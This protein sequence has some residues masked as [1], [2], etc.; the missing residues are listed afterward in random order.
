[1]LTRHMNPTESGDFGDFCKPPGPSHCPGFPYH[2]GG[3]HVGP[4]EVGPLE[5]LPGPLSSPHCALALG[6]TCCLLL[7]DPRASSCLPL[8]VAR[9]VGASLRRK[10][11]F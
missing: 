5:A 6:K 1:M 2:Q 8:V 11:V 9:V 4:L 3:G 7:S 10:L